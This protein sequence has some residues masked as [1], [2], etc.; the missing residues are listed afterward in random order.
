[1]GKI[2]LFVYEYKNDL[3]VK[4]FQYKNGKLTEITE[5]EYEYY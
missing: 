2:L 1:M 3:L 5:M 4:T